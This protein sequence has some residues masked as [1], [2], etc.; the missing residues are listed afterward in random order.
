MKTLC[1]L[2]AIAL[3]LAALTAFALAHEQPKCHT[4]GAAKHSECR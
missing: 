1:V 3:T 2:I 4:H